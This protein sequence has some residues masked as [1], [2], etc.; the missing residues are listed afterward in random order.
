MK[1][2]SETFKVNWIPEL[3]IF[4][5]NKK[6]FFRL[7]MSKRVELASSFICKLLVVGFRRAQYKKSL[8]PA[9]NFPKKTL[10]RKYL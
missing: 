8:D 4:N 5:M 1:E 9:P 2:I 10:F 6:Y 3:K 7:R